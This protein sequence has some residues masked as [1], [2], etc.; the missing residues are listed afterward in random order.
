M[1]Q[2]RLDVQS[3]HGRDDR[4]RVREKKEAQ[5][6]MSEKVQKGEQE[7]WKMWKPQPRGRSIVFTSSSGQLSWP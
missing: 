7:A 3:P 4:E 6:I 1:G 5:R 2:T